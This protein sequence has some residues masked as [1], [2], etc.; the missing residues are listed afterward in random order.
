MQYGRRIRNVDG[1]LS[2][3][4]QLLRSG[5]VFDDDDDDDL[6][7]CC[8]CTVFV[9]VIPCDCECC[10]WRR[11]SIRFE[12]TWTISRGLLFP[13]LLIVYNFA[14]S[15]RSPTRLWRSQLLTS[16]TLT[17][18]GQID[19]GLASGKAFDHAKSNR[20]PFTTDKMNLVD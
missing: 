20:Q 4:K 10:S 18:L 12:R 9:V 8:C 1:E 6:C 14:T 7:C 15:S 13:L 5:T 3:F 19:C 16:G 11:V 2:V 17:K